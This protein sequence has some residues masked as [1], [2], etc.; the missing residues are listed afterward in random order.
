MFLQSG[1]T[2]HCCITVESVPARGYA[3]AWGRRTRDA[4]GDERSW[5]R[6]RTDAPACPHGL[7]DSRRC[8]HRRQSAASHSKRWLHPTSI[9]SYTSKGPLRCLTT[10]HQ[11]H[12]AGSTRSREL[13]HPPSGR[14]YVSRIYHIRPGEPRWPGLPKLCKDECPE[15]RVS[16]QR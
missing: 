8:P 4:A 10:R 12:S 2:S 3:N 1:R 15:E 9:G 6:S 5:V 16:C 7:A 13:P 14:G 11:R